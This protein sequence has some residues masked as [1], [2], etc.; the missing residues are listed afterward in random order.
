MAIPKRLYILQ[1][2][3][4]DEEASYHI[5]LRDG[6]GNPEEDTAGNFVW[7]FMHDGTF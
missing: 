5:R 6:Q 3:A 4:T 7:N 2:A 1:D